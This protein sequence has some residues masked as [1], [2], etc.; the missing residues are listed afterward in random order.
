MLDLATFPQ[1]GYYQ[2]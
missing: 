1:Q 2:Y